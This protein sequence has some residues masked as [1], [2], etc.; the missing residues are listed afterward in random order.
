MK[1]I[2]DVANAVPATDG[3]KQK[4]AGTKDLAGFAGD[5][6]GIA[7][8]FRG[9]IYELTKVEDNGVTLVN[10]SSIELANKFINAL[11]SIIEAAN[12]MPDSKWGDN[13]AEQ[14]VK[15]AAKLG[16]IA[17]SFRGAVWELKQDNV[18]DEFGINAMTSFIQFL[19]GLSSLKDVNIEEKGKQLESA[20]GSMISVSH[21]M[22]ELFESF[23]DL[24][25]ETIE[26]ITEKIGNIIE[27]FT[28]FNTIEDVN[29]GDKGTALESFGGS[30][31]SFCNKLNEASNSLNGI[32]NDTLE[33]NINKIKKF[34]EAATSVNE[35]DGSKIEAFADSLKK[36]SESGVSAFSDNMS[37]EDSK[38]KAINSVSAFIDSA[39]DAVNEERKSAVQTRFTEIST[40]AI[41][42]LDNNGETTTKFYEAGS[43]FVQGFVNAINN[44]NKA[45]TAA[46]NLGLR[47]VKG[48]KAG[49]DEHSP[50]K[51]TF[52]TGKYFVQGFINGVN[53][54]ADNLY[55]NVYELGNGT[56]NEFTNV[57]SRISDIINSDV[58][59]QPTIRPVLDLSDV[60][61]GAKSINSM[62]NIGSNIG[63]SSNLSS[64]STSINRQLQNRGNNDVV[65]AIDSLSKSLSGNTGNT[66]NVNGITYN[67]EGDVSDAIRTLIKATQIERR[68]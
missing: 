61:S 28:S 12:S 56:T 3:W 25:V 52:Q 1:A 65:S 44:E 22:K 30:L 37:S 9:M 21:K 43:N 13:K 47:A 16:E 10:D 15:F 6:G 59:A 34:E 67:D 41:N 18:L 66:Y 54:Y 50:S 39:K 68:M 48:V 60:E 57:I 26:A 35:I 45:Y 55:D 4:I 8:S 58:D 49:T 42:G 31:I 7:E 53:K 2:A 27:V 46:Y 23:K 11:K 5:L 33:G 38:N 20:T 19:Y 63:L 51:L 29:L 36:L 40:S 62:L 14:L 17:K 64:I 24:T 32:D